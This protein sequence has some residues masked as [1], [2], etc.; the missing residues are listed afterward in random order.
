MRLSG[1]AAPVVQSGSRG[2]NATPKAKGFADIPSGDRALY[3]WTFAKWY[4][5]HGLA[6]WE[7]NQ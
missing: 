2:G 7:P 5:R 6:R 4:E 1:R 3:Q